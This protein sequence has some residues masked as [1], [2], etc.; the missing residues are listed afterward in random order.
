[1][2]TIRALFFLVLKSSNFIHRTI[3][4]TPQSYSK[5]KNEPNTI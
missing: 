1:M 3:L 2:E 4:R 5:E